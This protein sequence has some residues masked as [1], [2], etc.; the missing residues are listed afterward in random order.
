M[1]AKVRN[2][3]VFQLE[4]D[5]FCSDSLSREPLCFRLP[6]IIQ[7]LLRA[8]A[9]LPLKFPFESAQADAEMPGKERSLIF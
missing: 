4:G 8:G 1:S 2:A 7:L 3:F 5:F 9:Q 6:A